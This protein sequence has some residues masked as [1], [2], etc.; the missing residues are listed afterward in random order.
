MGERDSRVRVRLDLRRE[1]SSVQ[2]WFEFSS[3]S[4][5]LYREVVCLT[6]ALQRTAAIDPRSEWIW[7]SDAPFTIEPARQRRSLSF[8]VR[9]H[10]HSM[11]ETTKKLLPGWLMLVPACL[12]FIGAADA[13]YAR[14]GRGKIGAFVALG[15]VFLGAGIRLLRRARRKP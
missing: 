10:P 12:F 3:W 1:P 4:L 6:R 13:I 8:F 15:V 5:R 11:K 14:S 7:S 2:V 9:P